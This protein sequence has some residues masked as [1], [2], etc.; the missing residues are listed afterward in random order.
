MFIDNMVIVH[1]TKFVDIGTPIDLKQ[2]YLR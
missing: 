1:K 2:S